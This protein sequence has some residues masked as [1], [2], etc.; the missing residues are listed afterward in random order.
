MYHVANWIRSRSRAK[1]GGDSTLH[2]SHFTVYILY[3]IHWT[4]V[5]TVH[6]AIWRPVQ[7]IKF[8]HR[9]CLVLFI[10]KTLAQTLRF[11]SIQKDAYFLHRRSS[12]KGTLVS[13][14]H[15]LL[16]HKRFSVN[17]IRENNFYLKHVTNYRDLRFK[18]IKRFDVI[19]LVVSS[20]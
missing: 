10:R 6:S 18:S 3:F 1:T 15:I 4:K 16:Q 2:T 11:I 20:T 13:K 5:V 14:R 8:S 9:K 12:N 19:G 7:K 17:V